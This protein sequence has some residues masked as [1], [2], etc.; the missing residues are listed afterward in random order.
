MSLQEV[1]SEED[2]PF[3]LGVSYDTHPLQESNSIEEAQQLPAENIDRLSLVQ[4]KA[5]LKTHHLKKDVSLKARGSYLCSW[6]PKRFSYQSILDLHANHFH[7]N[8]FSMMS[9][10]KDKALE[11]RQNVPQKKRSF[12]ISTK[13]KMRP[14]N[15]LHRKKTQTFQNFS[16]FRNRLPFN[17][18][19][20]H[21][22]NMVTS[23]H[24]HFFQCSMC[25]Y[26]T[27]YKHTFDRHSLKHTISQF[28]CNQCQMPFLKNENL[29]THLKLKH[30]NI[31]TIPSLSVWHQ[32]PHCQY[33][34][35]FKSLMDRH[36]FKHNLATHT[37][38]IC[39]MPFINKANIF[40]HMKL[41]HLNENEVLVDRSPKV[42][43]QC[44]ICP[45][46][47]HVYSKVNWHMKI[48]HYSERYECKVCELF[49]PSEVALE[50][51]NR[52]I[53]SNTDNGNDHLELSSTISLS[54]DEPTDQCF[55]CPCCLNRLSDKSFLSQTDV[56]NYVCPTCNMAFSRQLLIQQNMPT[57]ESKEPNFTSEESFNNY[58]ASTEMHHLS[59][60]QQM[61][62]IYRQSED[63]QNDID[64][65]SKDLDSSTR[66]VDPSNQIG[67]VDFIEIDDD[68]DDDDVD[69]IDVDANEQFNYP[70]ILHCN[71][72][73]KDTNSNVCIEETHFP[74]K[75]NHC[76]PLMGSSNETLSTPEPSTSIDQSNTISKR[77]RYVKLV[78]DFDDFAERPFA[79]ALCY[80][81]YSQFKQLAVHVKNH[82]TGAGGHGDVQISFPW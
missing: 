11:S 65:R 61:E 57:F 42:L 25:E 40:Y 81:R 21:P 58:P 78:S 75:D 6:C 46:T 7:L 36:I 13:R 14:K 15:V 67:S 60:I 3:A 43:H 10:Y 70:R 2:N 63:L 77:G 1:C 24:T 50:E 45:Y 74:D 17:H 12:L 55:Y 68:D 49:L 33:N 31:S 29:L 80:Q 64:S 20:N 56:S 69:R 16:S 79:C 4:K 18:Q 51:H 72:S 62:E 82:L 35:S 34:T 8:A 5:N 38:D 76:D 9:S 32:C 47:S 27:D 53:H 71:S 26:K 39:Q 66:H 44:P 30:S 48:Q 19:M 28:K 22:N 73:D 54:T 59:D 23:E 41:K 52:Q 37:C